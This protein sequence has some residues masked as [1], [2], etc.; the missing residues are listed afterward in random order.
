MKSNRRRFL[1]FISGVL[2][3]VGATL[4][5]VPLL[6][7]FVIPSHVKPPQYGKT[8]EIS[9]LKPGEMFAVS[10]AGRPLY[11]LKRTPEQL[12]SLQEPYRQLRDAMS[13]SSKQ[14]AFARNS[15]RSLKPEIF[16][17]WGICTHLGCSVSYAPAH[18]VDLNDSNLKE[19]GGF[20]CPCHG[21]K[22]D[23]AG[24]VYKNVPAP[25]NLAIPN[26]EFVNE[27]TIRITDEG[28]F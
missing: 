24:R 11:V 3:G 2:A 9:K 6:R 8:I 14:P 4:A 16:V 1:T 7:S 18:K 10:I 13:V 17:A 12:Q 26:Y 19:N 25:L 21:S 20:G 5:T 28:A 15:Y 23:A 22:Y 27:T